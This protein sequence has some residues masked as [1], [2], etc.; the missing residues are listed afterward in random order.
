MPKIYFM[1]IISSGA[2][3]LT[4]NKNPAA[5]EKPCINS[6]G[7]LSKKMNDDSKQ[8]AYLMQVAHHGQVIHGY[9]HAQAKEWCTPEI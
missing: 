8:P 1:L 2:T 6:V 4:I 9:R 3:F 7:I 5:S